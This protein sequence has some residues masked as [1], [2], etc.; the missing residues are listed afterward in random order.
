MAEPS[1]IARPYAE[2]I[3][4]LADQGGK[5][6][7]WSDMLAESARLA[8]DERIDAAMSDPNFSTA[9][10]AG[11]FLAVL[12]GKLSGDARTSFECSPRTGA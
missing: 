7:E 6:A 2:A 11:M 1:T 12:A 8:V 5:L 10:V 9:K 4:R 3:Y